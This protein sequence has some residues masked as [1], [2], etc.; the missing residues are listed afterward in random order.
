MAGWDTE[1]EGDTPASSEVV[2]Q[3][4]EENM[5]AREEMLDDAEI[6]QLLLAASQD[7]EVTEEEVGSTRRRFGSPVSSAS[8]EEARKSGVPLKTCRQTSWACGVWASWVRDRKTLP[9]VNA[10]QGNNELSEDITCMSMKALQF[11][12]PKF[13]LEVRR[14]DK[15]NYPPD[16]LYNICASLQKFND[17][18]AFNR[19]EI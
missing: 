7:Y 19:S 10:L 17:R 18:G 15:Q 16:S 6:D 8:V 3:D 14:Q 12:L 1:D 11:W 4:Q 9:V 5:G 13:V 2:E